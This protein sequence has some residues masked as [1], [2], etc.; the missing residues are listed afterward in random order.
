MKKSSVIVCLLLLT[1][2]ILIRQ[3]LGSY[4]ACTFPFKW[5]AQIETSPLV[6]FLFYTWT[7]GLAIYYLAKIK[8]QKRS[9]HGFLVLLGL[10]TAIYCTER[11]L[12]TDWT[13]FPNYYSWKYL[14]FICLCA[15]LEFWNLLLLSQPETTSKSNSSLEAEKPLKDIQED[16]FNRAGFAKKIASEIDKSFFDQ[17]FAIAVVGQWSSG[18]SS[19]INLILKQLEVKD[20]IFIRFSPWLN[21]DQQG[22]LRNFFHTLKSEIGQLDANLNSQFENYYRSISHIESKVLIPGLSML[23]PFPQNLSLK[24]EFE[25]INKSLKRLG[26][27][28]IIVI[29]DLDRLDSSE[30]VELFKLIR[31]TGNFYNTIYLTAFDRTYVTNAVKQ[32]NDM[33]P[34]QFITKIFDLEYALP[35]HNNDYIVSL[36]NDFLRNDLKTKHEIGPYSKE[37]EVVKSL[38]PTKRD[39]VRFKNHLTLTWSDTTAELSTEEVLVMELLRARYPAVVSYFYKNYRELIDWLEIMR[40]DKIY[41][42]VNDK[43]GA[44]VLRK[45]LEDL[46]SHPAVKMHL[47]PLSI[48]N[49]VS[50]FEFLFN[51][52][53]KPLL[54]TTSSTELAFNS[55]R[56]KQYLDIY[57]SLVFEPFAIRISAFQAALKTDWERCK[58]HID[59][60]ILSEPV[61]AK[62]LQVFEMIRKNFSFYIQN[63]TVYQN[64]VKMLLRFESVGI[65]IDRSL[66]ESFFDNQDN[67]ISLAGGDITERRRFFTSIFTSNEFSDQA[68]SN[69]LNQMIHRLKN[70]REAKFSLLRVEELIEI[71]AGIFK[72]HIERKPVVGNETMGLYYKNYIATNSEGNV[73][74]N[75]ACTKL[76]GEFLK[77]GENSHEFFNLLIR[78]YGSGVFE[79][80]FVFAPYWGELFGGKDRFGEFLKDQKTYKHRDILLE[81]FEKYKLND[82]KFFELTEDELKGSPDDFYNMRLRR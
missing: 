68:R 49:I 35:E 40:V 57:F 79:N 66:L 60:Y 41:S 28:I 64:T 69:L 81:Y 6:S 82:F 58:N 74:L 3:P 61:D 47:S 50:A 31:N 53:E 17:A 52:R 65:N 76:F 43:S 25:Q 72:M 62:A 18:K 42:L 71:N 23:N 45:K 55:I 4:L 37:A 29:D 24:D 22:V 19:F 75:P 7:V 34:D 44:P 12:F 38:L 80:Q 36:L 70:S 30:I 2:Y 13:F 46:E 33:T 73:V 39:F 56:R 15:A 20:K 8:A 5:A 10:T 9:N 21:Y 32:M 26:K 16:M 78:P 11:F 51:E 54:E 77:Q 1:I 14:D 63:R 59:E 27:Q 67:D 48:D